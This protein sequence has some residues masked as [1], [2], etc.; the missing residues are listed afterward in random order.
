ML[1]KQCMARFSL[2]LILL[3]LVAAAP[4]LAGSAV[5]GSV[6][7][8]MNATVGGQ[9]L[10]PNTTLFSGDSL[11][12]KDGV[13]V[14][15]LG[16]ASRVVF[17]RDTA[18]SFLRDSNEVTVLLGQGSVSV[19]H[20]VEGT[21]VRLKIGDLTVVPA[22][23]FRTLG[24]VAMLNGAVVVT[25]KEG[26]LR[27][28]GSDGQVVNVAKGKT[29]TVVPAAN[30]PQG[31]G[32][33]P[34]GGSVGRCCG[35]A[36]IW[37]VTATIAGGAAAVLAGV[38]VSRAGTAETNASNAASAAAAAAAAASA[39]ISAA[40]A[41]ASTALFNTISVGCALNALAGHPGANSPYVPPGNATCANPS[42]W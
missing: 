28:Q 26:L 35:G 15:A 8:S 13:A 9:T 14:V 30:A 32:K 12:V 16:S 36:S 37:G 3:G 4:A 6:A 10:L 39:A 1:S 41:A 31:G 33:P 40:N 19:F 7:G 29:V 11:Q 38:A 17:G 18:A 22:S 34:G 27:V 24:E 21:P 5:V 25:T 42:T 20:E 23:D 2:C